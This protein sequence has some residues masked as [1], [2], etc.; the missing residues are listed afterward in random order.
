LK[1]KYGQTGKTVGKT[2]GAASKDAIKELQLSIPI[3]GYQIGASGSQVS[4]QI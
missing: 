3:E 4:N 1:N 2:D